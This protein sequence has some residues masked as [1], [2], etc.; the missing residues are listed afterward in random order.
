M[1]TS[2]AKLE[3]RGRYGCGWD[4]SAFQCLELAEHA[5]SCCRI[6]KVERIEAK[7][8]EMPWLAVGVTGRKS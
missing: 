7:T 3:Q 2:A 5:A 4:E 8:A 1:H 6:G